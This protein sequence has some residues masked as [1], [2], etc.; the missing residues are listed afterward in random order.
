METIK[1]L[2]NQLIA[3]QKEKVRYWY[4]ILEGSVI[5]KNSYARVTLGKNA[6]IGISEDEHYLCDYIAGAD[7]VLAM[8]PYETLSHLTDIIKGQAS[9]RETLIRA[10]ITQRQMLLKAYA[11]FQSL[12]HK[13][14]FFVENQYNDYTDLCLKYSLECTGFPRID[15]FKP[16][17]MTHRAEEWEINNS[18][19]LIQEHQEEYIQLMQKSDALCIG[20]ILE[21]ARQTKRVTQ[22]INEMMAYLEYNRDI[23]LSE[24][25]H[26]IFRLYFELL[27]RAD[28]NHNDT[29]PLTDNMDRMAEIIKVLGIYD[30]GL[31]SRRMQE[32]Q[33][34][35]ING[36]PECGHDASADAAEDTSPWQKDELSGE[37]YL[38]HILSYAD[39]EDEK[40]EEIC[41]AFRQFQELPDMLST[42][43][44]TNRLRKS[45]ASIY[46]DVYHKVFM[47][48]IK[49]SGELSPVI[50]MFLNFGFMDVRLAGEENTS[51]LYDLTD[52]LNL[53]SSDH[54]YTIYTWLKSV[55]EGKNE[56]S[57]NEFDLDYTAYL[58]E[59]KK[60]GRLT[61]DQAAACAQDQEMKLQYELQNMFVSGNRVTYGRISTFCP[62]L[63]EHDLINSIDKMLV[64]V[65]KLEDSIEKIKKVDFSAFYREVSFSDPEKGINMELIQKEV[66]PDIILMPNAGTRAMMWQE[67]AGRKR[68]SSARFMFPIFTPVD[69][70][71]MMIE[72]IGRY[73][74]EICRRIQGVHWNDIREPSLTADYCDYIQFYRKNHELSADAKEKIKLAL[75]RGR[76][77]YREVFVKDYQNWIKFESKGSF[78]LNKIAREILLKYCPFSK[79]IREELKANPMYQNA[80]QRYDILN[81]KALQRITAVFSRYQKA[82]GKI[83]QEIRNHLDYYNL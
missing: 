6:V 67:I 82:G 61:A 12:V 35:K 77:N 41:A 11:G 59:L 9:M 74:W 2:K 32:Y 79:P 53:C 47:R 66:M 25:S 43:A 46:Y 51:I 17:E 20:A 81:A 83:T 78:R 60:S 27:V 65:Q 23:L 62:I 63:C 49:E 5:Q 72:T 34:Y 22:G 75:Q 38:L 8:Y 4:I 48:A 45:L 15:N 69:L 42:D 58:A 37:D 26:D 16:L 14:H 36:L 73:R 55:Y 24:S 50:Q 33:N 80:F 3:Q 21:A 29:K 40:R 7:S 13:F 1:V 70:D 52:H 39:L 71:D 19:A 44:E 10:A 57:K 28:A 54:V 76:N 31:V 64:T 68:D 30:S 18:N 56:P